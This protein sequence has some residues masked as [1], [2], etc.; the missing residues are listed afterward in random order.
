[1]KYK[2]E[3]K[4]V[5]QEIEKLEKEWDLADKNNDYRKCEKITEIL[6]KKNKLK[7]VLEFIIKFGAP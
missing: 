1:M 5:N 3:L 2:L 7:K 4:K 6:E